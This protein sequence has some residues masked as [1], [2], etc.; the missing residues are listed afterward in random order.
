MWVQ[1]GTCSNQKSFATQN[2]T[3]MTHEVWW[4]TVLCPLRECHLG[5]TTVEVRITFLTLDHHLG[6]EKRRLR[7]RSLMFWWETQNDEHDGNGTG[8]RPRASCRY[9]LELTIKNHTIERL[10][11]PGTSSLCSCCST[12][13]AC[14]VECGDYMFWNQESTLLRVRQL[15]TTRHVQ[16]LNSL[17]TNILLLSWKTQGLLALA[18]HWRALTS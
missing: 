3:M 16:Q 10:A 18:Q 12:E 14:F 2:W 8:S 5:W 9:T 7:R 1:R 11:E 13:F 17:P 15:G 6:E 4:S